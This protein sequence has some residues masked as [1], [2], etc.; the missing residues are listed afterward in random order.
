MQVAVSSVSY[1][2]VFVDTQVCSSPIMAGQFAEGIARLIL[3]DIAYTQ[4]IPTGMSG[5]TTFLG[6]S[7]LISGETVAKVISER[8]AILGIVFAIWDIKEG[9]S[10]IKGSKHAT[11]YRDAAEKIDKSTSQYQEILKQ[12][13]EMFSSATSAQAH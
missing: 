10:D 4:G 6:R 1:V 11:A 8:L 5:L 2:S 12:I 3:A 7:L 9:V 13:N